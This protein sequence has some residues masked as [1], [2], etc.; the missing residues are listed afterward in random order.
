MRAN[1]CDGGSDDGDDGGERRRAARKL[2]SVANER[3]RRTI[4]QKR[5]TVAWRLISGIKVNVAG[6]SSRGG[7]PPCHNSQF[8]VW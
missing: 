7:A 8:L 6:L 4:R 1:R 5:K 2:A 3:A